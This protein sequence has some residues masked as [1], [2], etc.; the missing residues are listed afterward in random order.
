MGLVQK[1]SLIFEPFRSKKRKGD[2]GSFHLKN[3]PL[4]LLPPQSDF[5]AK[6]FS[7]KIFALS[8]DWTV[9]L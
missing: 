7:R 8:V 6:N 5:R 4:E 2:K 1:M 9:E 3:Y